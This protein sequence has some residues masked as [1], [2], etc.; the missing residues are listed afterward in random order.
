MGNVTDLSTDEGEDPPVLTATEAGG[1]L[2]GKLLHEDPLIEHLSEDEQ[3]EYVLRNKKKGVLIEREHG[4]ERVEPHRSYQ[5]L[6]VATD[7]RLLVVVGQT[8][9]D[10]T[11]TIHFADV[12]SVS[13]EDGIFGGEIAVVTADDERYVFPCRGD[14]E[15]V[16]TYVDEATQAWARAY[17]LLDTADERLAEASDLNE[18]ADFEAAIEAVDAARASLADARD[19]LAAFG[20]G[21]GAAFEGTAEDLE[22]R[23]ERRRRAVHAAHGEH[24]HEAAREH[25]ERRE[26]DDAYDT[27]AEA[28]A[29]LERAMAISEDAAV[30][31]RLE[32]LREEWNNLAVAPLAYAEAMAD[33]ARETDRPGT[34]AQCWEVAMERYRDVYALD[35]GREERRFDVEPEGVRER[36]VQTL[37]SAVECR[38]DA[39]RQ[40]REEAADLRADG[41]SVAARDR[42]ETALAGLERAIDLVDELRREDDEELLDER[43]TIEAALTDLDRSLANP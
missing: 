4:T 39:A 17:T 20:A 16:G 21:A 12:V 32:R 27:Y 35:W 23:I 15:P 43:A 13:V 24:A 41:N 42:L 25:W 18:D 22:A 2:G 11:E 5:A 6:C 29:A 31:E 10:T 14:L 19:R 37:E 26:Y 40:A 9:K 3:A 36:V 28:E 34:A 1:L 7:V 33:E 30:A 38:I 8:P